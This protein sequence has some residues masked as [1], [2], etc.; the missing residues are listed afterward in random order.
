[1]SFD[2][3][4]N[5]ILQVTA[6]DRTTGREQ[7]ITIQGASTLSEDEVQRMVREAEEYAEVDRQRKAKVEKRTK[8]EALTFQAERQLRDAMLDY[9]SQFVSSHR[10]R[11]ERAVQ[12]LREA[13]AQ[14][15][16]RGIDRFQADLQ[17]AVYDLTRDVYQRNKEE[18]QEE[19]L[20]GAIKSFFTD[21]DDN[22]YYDQRDGNRLGGYGNYGYGGVGYGG[23]NRNEYRYGNDTYGNRD[24][25]D[26]WQNDRYDRPANPDRYDQRSRRDQDGQGSPSPRYEDRNWD[27]RYGDRDDTDSR[28]RSSRPDPY[29][30]WDNENRPAR[31]SRPD[32]SRSDLDSREYPPAPRPDTRRTSPTSR[33][34]DEPRLSSS[35]PREGSSRTPRVSRSE[36]GERSPYDASRRREPEPDRYQPRPDRRSDRTPPRT[37]RP[38][39]PPDV[40]DED[41]DW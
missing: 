33:Q 8:A 10:S 38:S 15:D 25:N 32:S 7:S 37:P 35:S 14:N 41:D 31:P 34:S 6:M 16:D 5:G 27:N 26:R 23:L 17:D 9:G 2:V 11:I 24:Y 39:A 18:E 3:D 30:R 22:Y 40:W 29:D 19:S 1:V 28:N 4:A 12:Q 36:N 20:L 21:D 13:L